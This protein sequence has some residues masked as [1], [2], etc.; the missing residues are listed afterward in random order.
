ME[1]KAA[2]N[3]RKKLQVNPEPILFSR[4]SVKDSGYFAH[5]YTYL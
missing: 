4:P 3:A 1:A 2:A 5:V